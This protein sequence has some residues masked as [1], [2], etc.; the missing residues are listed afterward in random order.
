LEGVSVRAVILTAGLLSVMG[1]ITG[2][3]SKCEAVCSEANTCEVKDRPTDVDCPEYCADVDN[4]NARA[5]DAGQES[6]DA[7]FQKHLDC[8]ETNSKQI[9]NTEFEGCVEAAQAFVDCMTTYCNAM[10]AEKQSDPNCDPGD[11]DDPE[12]PATPLL[13]AF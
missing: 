10:K 5:K 3:S 6:C 13:P 7:Q 2:C 9:C 11:P 4:F 8:W 1:L 12:E